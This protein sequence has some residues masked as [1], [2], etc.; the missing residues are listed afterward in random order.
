MKRIM[1][2]FLLSCR[3]ATSLIEK[4]SVTRLSL[5]EKIGLSMHKKICDACRAYEKQSNTLDKLIKEST[6]GSLISNDSLKEK[7]NRALP[8]QQ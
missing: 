3:K 2:F 1:H 5:K 7:I 4:K 6:P 8:D